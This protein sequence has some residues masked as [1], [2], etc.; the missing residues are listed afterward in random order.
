[1]EITG[2]KDSNTL[3]KYKKVNNKAI[4]ELTKDL[5]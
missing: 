1:M 5:F 4:T 2:I 3:K